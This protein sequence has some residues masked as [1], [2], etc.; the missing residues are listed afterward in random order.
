MNDLTIPGFLDRRPIVGTFTSM[1]CYENTCPYQANKRFIEKV[2]PFVETPEIL[3]GRKVHEAFDRRV[4]GKQPLPPDMAKWEQFATPFD[5][6]GAY[7]ELKL[8]ISIKGTLTEYFG[9]DVRFRCNLDLALVNSEKAY[10][11]DYKTGNSKYESKF[12]LEVQAMHL[13]AKFPALKK[14][15]GRYIWLKENRPGQTYDLSDTQSPWNKCNMILGKMEAD[16]KADHFEKRKGPLC[17][18]C[19]CVECEYNTSKK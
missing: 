13:H 11:Q 10:L 6:K 5:G 7:T 9:Q 14:I 19:P 15:I 17:G 18:W 16:R 12:E 1:S 4:S 2:Y 8:A 3:Y